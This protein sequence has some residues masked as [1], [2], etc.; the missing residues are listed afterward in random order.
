MAGPLADALADA[1][2]EAGTGADTGAGFDGSSGRL[3]GGAEVALLLAPS[4]AGSFAPRPSDRRVHTLGIGL[5]DP[6]SPFCASFD[7]VID[8][9][10][11]FDRPRVQALRA[12]C[13]EV[14]VPR[15][16]LRAPMWER[17]PLDRWVEVRSL[18]GAVDA[19][20]SIARIALLALPLE[21]A[22][23]FEPVGGLRFPVRL[24]STKPLSTPLSWTLPPRFAPIQAPAPHSIE[25]ERLILRQTEAQ[26]VVMR[27]TG[28]A[29]LAPLIAAAR[30]YDL[31][32]LM[33]RR[34]MER[35]ER[36]ARSIGAAME[37][38]ER[39]LEDADQAGTGETLGSSAAGSGVSR[40]SPNRRSPTRITP[41]RGST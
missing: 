4:R 14:G 1:L 27:A 7:V 36:P 37:W 35:D 8:G 5:P 20:A 22:A 38:V 15:L 41:D 31:P 10:D 18:S 32:V 33:I 24:T 23:A 16:P 26:A 6:L 39:H 28:E 40:R 19:V 30:G 29:D 9:L 34:P 12:A 13:R 2:V 3:S 11:P 25:R 21:D 17:H